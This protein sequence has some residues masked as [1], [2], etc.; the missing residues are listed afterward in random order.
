[1]DNH[2]YN[3]DAISNDEYRVK[4]IDLVNIISSVEWVG[5]YFDLR[6]KEILDFGCGE[7]TTALGMALQRLPKRVVGIEIQDEYLR[8]KSL[9]RDQIQLSKLPGNLDLR[10]ISPEQSLEVFGTFD[11]VY[12]W[13]VFE[14]VEQKSIS[15]VLKSIYNVLKPGGLFFLQIDPLYYSANGAHL[16]HWIS[17]PWAH[18]RYQDSILFENLRAACP[19]S[20]LSKELIHVY[21]TLNKLTAYQLVDFVCDTGFEIL[22]DFR[23]YTEVTPSDD[24]L[25]VFTA[26]VLTTSQIVLLLK[27]PDIF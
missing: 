26:D 23:S 18:L 2:Q 7:A 15:R 19:E 14:H 17:E 13:S 4:F 20:H 22:R 21:Q 10:K 6:D 5:K 9:A 11:L 8:C 3:K 1:M 16:N 12:S 24:L 27:R 25:K